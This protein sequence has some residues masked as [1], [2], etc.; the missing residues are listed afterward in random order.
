MTIARKLRK[1]LTDNFFNSVD[2]VMIILKKEFPTKEFS[3]IC[4]K[5][6]DTVRIGNTTVSIEKSTS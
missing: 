3:I 2:E 6:K 1:I 5:N 4:T